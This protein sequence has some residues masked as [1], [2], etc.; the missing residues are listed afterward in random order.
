MGG[1][2]RVLAENS[3]IAL[4]GRN[5]LAPTNTPDT[6]HFI[7][8]PPSARTR[9]GRPICTTLNATSTQVEQGKQSVPAAAVAAANECFGLFRLGTKCASHAQKSDKETS[10]DRV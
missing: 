10:S 3:E 1:G 8:M 7:A 6:L 2:D 9:A 5:E 4:M